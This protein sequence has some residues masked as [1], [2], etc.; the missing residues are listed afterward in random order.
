MIHYL[1]Y[2]KNIY[3][4]WNSSN[5]PNYPNYLWLQIS[6]R[7][8]SAINNESQLAGIVS[9]DRRSVV[10]IWRSTRCSGAIFAPR[11]K[12]DIHQVHL[13]VI[14]QCH[15][16]HFPPAK[17]SCWFASCFPVWLCSS[18]NDE[19]SVSLSASPCVREER[20]SGIWLVS[21]RHPSVTSFSAI[22]QRCWEKW[23]IWDWMP[24]LASHWSLQ[25]HIGVFALVL[26]SLC[27]SPD[28][29]WIITTLTWRTKCK[30][31][32]LRWWISPKILLKCT[33]KHTHTC[34]HSCLSGRFRPLS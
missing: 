22:R 13:Y 18:V 8:S 6:D 34:I 1:T 23:L 27:F 4:C 12:P 16:S 20:H 25:P 24:R 30:E 14:R 31:A 33:D 26:K 28:F 3:C 9:D 19:G 10:G 7:C 29:R 32:Q 17:S 2:A 15:I 21:L 11:I 5:K